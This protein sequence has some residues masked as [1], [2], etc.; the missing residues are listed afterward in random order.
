LND[1]LLK[2]CARVY[3]CGLSSVSRY[4]TD[5]NHLNGVVA[6]SATVDIPDLFY[7]SYI[8]HHRGND[9]MELPMNNAFRTILA[10]LDKA[11][12]ERRENMT[13]PFQWF[14]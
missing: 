10:K 12:I 6:C 2:C 8:L 1:A 13:E 5:P 4:F 9:C 14:T 3:N 7:Q 11:F